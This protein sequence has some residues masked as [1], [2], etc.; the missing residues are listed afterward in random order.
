MNVMVFIKQR[1]N[2]A[3]SC[4]RPML[5]SAE[6]S[7][8]NDLISKEDNNAL[9]AARKLKHKLPESK[10]IILFMCRDEQEEVFLSCLGDQAEIIYRVSDK[11]SFQ[12]QKWGLITNLQKSIDTVKARVGK[13]DAVFSGR[14]NSPDISGRFH[15]PQVFHAYDVEL[16]KSTMLISKLSGEDVKVLKAK[17]PCSVGFAGADNL[18]SATP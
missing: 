12:T 11:S 9:K 16:E 7:C 17:L 13:I 3:E 4:Q 14:K 5:L 18:R 10:I 6:S 8:L 2:I 1:E 15:Y